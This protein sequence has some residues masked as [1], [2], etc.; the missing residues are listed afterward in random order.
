MNHVIKEIDYHIMEMTI[1]RHSA[2]NYN[3]K[4]KKIP[5]S[6]IEDKDLRNRKAPHQLDFYCPTDG[7]QFKN[8]FTVF[9]CSIFKKSSIDIKSYLINA[10]WVALL[11]EIDWN[12]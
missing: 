10:L 8:R 4:G 5:V 9:S 1:S 2:L 6:I 7:V 3:I 11:T 12:L